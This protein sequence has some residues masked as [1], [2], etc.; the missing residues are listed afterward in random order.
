[1]TKKMFFYS[2]AEVCTRKIFK[3]EKKKQEEIIKFPKVYSNKLA[4]LLNL[5]N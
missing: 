5:K 3:N 4:Y 2:Q 1:M